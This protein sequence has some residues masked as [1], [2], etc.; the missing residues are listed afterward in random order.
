MCSRSVAVPAAGAADVCDELLAH[1]AA[2]PV[3][4]TQQSQ[5]LMRRIHARYRNPHLDVTGGP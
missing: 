5:H 3:D 1:F 2:H 4:R